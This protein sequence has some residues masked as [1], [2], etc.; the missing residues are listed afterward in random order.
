MT[1]ETLKYNNLQTEFPMFV[2]CADTQRRT[3]CTFLGQ[4]LIHFFTSVRQFYSLNF[5]QTS[6]RT[7]Y[8][9]DLWVKK[10]SDARVSLL[11]WVL[12]LKR[13]DIKATKS[14]FKMVTSGR[15]QNKACQ[16]ITAPSRQYG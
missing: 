10:C 12:F 11:F 7:I 6:T 8:L 9:N 2:F 1:A 15:Y 3:G 5:V 13:L 16:R 14:R 4:T